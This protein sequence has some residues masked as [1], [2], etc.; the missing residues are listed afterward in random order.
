MMA[1]PQVPVP[2]MKWDAW[3]DEAKAK[4][5]FDN[6]RALLQQALGVSADE[7]AGPDR[8]EVVLQPSALGD[9]DLRPVVVIQNDIANSSRLATVIVCALT[10]N[11]DRARA[12][13]NVL[14]DTGEGGLPRQ[15]VVNVS[16]VFT[17]HRDQLR[18]HIGRLSPGRVRHV[19]AGLW[20]LLEP[21]RLP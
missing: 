10:T 3:G 5:L 18:S 20:L 14:L 1:D 13:G 4:P 2:P 19:L 8:S 15:S 17:V 12:P 7:V 16:Q 9:D 6:I 11:L 21:R